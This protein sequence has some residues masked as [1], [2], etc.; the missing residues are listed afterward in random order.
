MSNLFLLLLLIFGGVALMVVVGERVL[1]PLEPEKLAR[2]SRWVYPLMGI[3]LFL[4][5]LKYLLA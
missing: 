3:A 5:L 4:A 2:L 1:Q